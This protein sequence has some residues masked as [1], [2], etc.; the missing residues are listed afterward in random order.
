MSDDRYS[1]EPEHPL[2]ATVSEPA[3]VIPLIPH[4]FGYQ[5]TESL[6]LLGIEPRIS[7]IAYAVRSDLPDSGESL[8]KALG[9]LFEALRSAL[10]AGIDSFIMVGIGSEERVRPLANAVRS[11]AALTGMSIVEGL[12]VDS[13]KPLPRGRPPA[14]AYPGN[15][16]A[17]ASS[18]RVI[19]MLGR[20]GQD[21]P[22]R[23]ERLAPLRP[24]TDTPS[25]AM[26]AATR[27]ARRWLA[28]TEAP[29][30]ATTGRELLRDVVARY[31]VGGE[32]TV[33]ETARLS[34]LLDDA[35]VVDA[36]LEQIDPDVSAPFCDLWWDM[37]QRVAVNAHVCLTMFAL[38]SYLYG[39][40]LHARAAVDQAIAVDPTFV[41]ARQIRDS[42]RYAEPP[43][44]TV[45]QR[46]REP[47]P[48]PGP[49][50]GSLTRRRPPA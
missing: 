45:W 49:T 26:E 4:V 2:T 50:P 30:V 28:T 25:E 21:L 35:T 33:E 48:T 16:D 23:Y 46:H 3:D 39:D 5:V 43:L 1:D 15:D 7:A 38:S 6:V 37:S 20:L 12:R 17:S 36:A 8:A 29:E 19:D 44:A 14:G 31:R 13:I 47:G 10:D 22:T 18:G 32:L 27:D 9:S 40:T 41:S 34:V 24:R 42:L 11:S